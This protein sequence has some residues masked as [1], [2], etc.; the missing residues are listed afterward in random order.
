MNLPHA[1]EVAQPDVTLRRRVALL[2]CELVPLHRPILVLRHALAVLVA[3]PEVALCARVALS[4]VVGWLLLILVGSAS[5]AR[6][7]D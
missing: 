4:L 1:V 5:F 2:R 3:L 7:P 6:L